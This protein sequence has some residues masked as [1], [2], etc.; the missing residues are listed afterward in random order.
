MT[1]EEV[2]PDLTSRLQA[3]GENALAVYYGYDDDLDD[4]DAAFGLDVCTC[5]T[6]LVREVLTGVWPVIEDFVDAQMRIILAE[7][8][9][10]Y[11][12]T[13]DL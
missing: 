7:Q 6:C 13:H 5:E 9:A 2:M 4:E 3:A 10:Q 8:S 11:T 12:I 1:A